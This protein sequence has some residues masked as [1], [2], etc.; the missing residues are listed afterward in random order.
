MDD[1]TDVGG[2]IQDF[3]STYTVTR[4]GAVDFDSDPGRPIA[5]APTTFDII[6]LVQPV[7][8]RDLERLPE[9]LRTEMVRVVFTEATML[10]EP[11]PDQ[12]AAEGQ[13]WQVGT[14]E[15]W[16]AGGFY[17]VLVKKVG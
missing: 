2:I 8:N 9:G 11:Q 7:K 1:L 3:G 12:L 6:A 4:A 14:V 5:A 17:K 15:P 10:L 16:G 13:V